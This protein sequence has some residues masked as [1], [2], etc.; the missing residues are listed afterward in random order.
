M[1]VHFWFIGIKLGEYVE[2]ALPVL[3]CRYQCVVLGIYVGTYG[4]TFMH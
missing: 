2:Q 1:Y 3:D 4:G